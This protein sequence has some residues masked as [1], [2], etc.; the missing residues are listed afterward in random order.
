MR[1]VILVLAAAAIFGAC[2]KDSTV[3]TSKDIATAPHVSVDRF[4]STFGHLFVRSATNGLPAANAPI[5][6]DV[7]PFIT[8][9]FSSTGAATMYY[10]F[11][12]LPTQT[13]DIYVFFK[14]SSPTIELTAQNHVLPS[15]PGMSGY[16]DFWQVSKVLVPDNYVVNSLTSE[17]AIRASGYSIQK[18]TNIVNCPVVPFGSTAVIKYGGGSNQLVAGWYKDSAV[19][20]FSFEEAPIT[21]NTAGQVPTAQIY[22]TFNDNT[23]GPASGFKTEAGTVQTHNVLDSAPGSAVYS[24]LWQVHVVDNT[25]FSSVKNLSTAIAAKSLNPNAALVNCPVVK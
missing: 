19:V 25:A 17:D 9:G 11:D 20:Y 5:S 18:T 8:T 3:P 13:D 2:K 10:N 12:V 16:N 15:L 24:P 22:V 21:V 7:A 14:A 6:F 23:T 1:R 4:S